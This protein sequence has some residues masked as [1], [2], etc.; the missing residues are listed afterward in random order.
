MIKIQ[1]HFRMCNEMVKNRPLI[2]GLL[3][4][5]KLFNI[6][7][8]LLEKSKQLKDENER[9]QIESQL[10]RLKQELIQFEK[11]LK[12]NQ[13]PNENSKPIQ[14]RYNSRR[15][16]VDMRLREFRNQLDDKVSL[17]KRK[18]NEQIEFIKMQKKLEEE[19]RK[20]E[21]EEMKRRQDEEKRRIKEEMEARRLKEEEEMKRRDELIRQEMIRKEQ[22]IATSAI[23]TNSNNYQNNDQATAKSSYFEL[24]DDIINEDNLQRK[25]LEQEKLDHNLAMRLASEM[26]RKHLEQQFMQNMRSQSNTNQSPVNN[27]VPPPLQISSDHLIN[28][29]RNIQANLKPNQELDLSKWKYSELRDV[30]N[31][32]CDLFLLECCK[33]GKLN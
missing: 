24:T 17:F 31:T 3:G 7:Q 9:N 10:N 12:T 22:K 30:I 13:I 18:M 21:E 33:K 6:N 28:G 14:Q 26:D 20:L 16:F 32:S 2:K 1:A 8:D 4:L 19:Q 29:L 23:A 15:E 25:R 11:V 5:R 27:N